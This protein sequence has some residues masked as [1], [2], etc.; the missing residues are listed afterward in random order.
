MARRR[1]TG[2]GKNGEVHDEIDGDAVEDTGDGSITREQG[3]TAGEQEEEED[4]AE[5]DE[6]VDREAKGGGLK[7][8]RESGMTEKA[9][10]DGLQDAGGRR[11]VKT[12]EDERV[13]GC[14]VSLR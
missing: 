9:A 13:R 7:A 12:I 10:G 1:D 5:G 14:R 6:V 11:A 4:P 8:T 3:E 2:Q